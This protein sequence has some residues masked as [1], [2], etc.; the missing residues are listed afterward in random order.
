MK[1]WRLS[2]F[3]S[4]LV[5]ALML[6]GCEPQSEAPTHSPAASS[7]AAPQDVV[8][9]PPTNNAAPEVTTVAASTAATSEPKMPKDLKTLP[10]ANAGSN[11][12]L[13]QRYA[14]IKN[15]IGQAK[16]S[17]VQQCRKV[18]FGYKACGGP[19]SYLIYSV[20]GLDEAVLLQKVGEYNAL[21]E[22]ESH[23]LGL[24]SDC[25]MVLE[26][27]VVLV[28]GVCKAGPSGDFLLR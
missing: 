18:P 2:V 22:A 16:A 11:E 26:P 4:I 13:K 23:R 5:F 17:D 25:A 6:G 1:P 15:M 10:V 28:E 14:E 24:I 9:V 8:D 20:Q 3:M 27:S 7:A 12:E 21:A 19:A